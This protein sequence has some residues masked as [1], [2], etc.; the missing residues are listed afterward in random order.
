MLSLP[1][2]SLDWHLLNRHQASFSSGIPTTRSRQEAHSTVAL[3]FVLSSPQASAVES[4]NPQALTLQV[5]IPHA[6]RFVL[7]LQSPFSCCSLSPAVDSHEFPVLEAFV[8]IVILS[9]KGMSTQ[10]GQAK[11][12]QGAAPL[13][14]KKTLHSRRA[15][16]RYREATQLAEGTHRLA[17]SHTYQYGLKRAPDTDPKIVAAG[18]TSVCLA[19]TTAVLWG[20]RRWCRGWN[21]GS[22]ACQ[23]GALCLNSATVGMQKVRELSTEPSTGYD[24]SEQSGS[25]DLQSHRDKANVAR[26]SRR[27]VI[28]PSASSKHHSLHQHQI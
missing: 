25:R 4:D 21:P 18:I 16:Q 23:T 17:K 11:A 1:T 24:W 9:V 13:W 14:V 20:F 5:W 8:G 15:A 6:I 26:A 19:Q 3:P 27:L 22:A 10:S 28:W 7:D 12:I 2:G